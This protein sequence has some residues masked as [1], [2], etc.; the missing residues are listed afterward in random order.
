MDA[1]RDAEGETV[2]LGVR[3]KDG[4]IKSLAKSVS[5]QTVRFDTDLTGSDPSFCTA[6]GRVLLAYWRPEKTAAYLARERIVH[7]TPHTVIDRVQIRRI[8]EAVRVN[9]Y[10]IS[11]EEAVLGGSGVAAPVRDS[12]GEVIAALNIAAV[13]ARFATSREQVLSAVIRNAAELSSRL[14]YKAST[15]ENQ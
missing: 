5:H 13:S 11:D 1:L 10:G 15:T 9:G 8:I 12:S 3:R 2:F 14:G 6:M 4:R 7:V